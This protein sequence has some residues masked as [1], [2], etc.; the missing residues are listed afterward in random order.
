MSDLRELYQEVILDHNKTP[1]NFGR[2]DG[3]RT[4]RPRATTRSAATSITVYADAST[5]DVVKD[6]ALRGLG[7]RDLD[8]LGVAD[9]REREGHGARP[10]RR[11]SSSASTTS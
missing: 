2:L 11:S 8:G 9:D 3:A 10:R 4:A 1:R 6:V 7:L 5:D